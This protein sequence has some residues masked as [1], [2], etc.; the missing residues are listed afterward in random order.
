LVPRPHRSRVIPQPPIKPRATLTQPATK[1]LPSSLLSELLGRVDTDKRLVILDMGHA[2]ASTV[3]FFGEYRCQLNFID[4]CAE[5]FI[6]TPD[7]EL[8]H[9]Q[10][11][12]LMREVLRLAPSAK[13]DICLFWDV[14]NYLDDAYIKALIEALEPYIS[15]A[16]AALVINP[17]D[18]RCYL[19]FCRYGI[20]DQDHFMQIDNIG[21]QPTVFAR[22]QRELNNLID[23][24]AI[25]RGRLISEGRAEY[26]L[27]ENRDIDK[28][29]RSMI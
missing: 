20:A 7:H 29:D 25:D 17:R 19:P 4:L 8:S 15:P 13:I 11:V 24:F 14:F 3:R 18:S 28:T 2:M 6:V 27:F 22:S 5:P 16:T 10:R 23:Y 12:I 9:N 26:L 21:A 1:L